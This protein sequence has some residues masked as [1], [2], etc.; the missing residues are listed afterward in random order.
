MSHGFGLVSCGT[1]VPFGTMRHQAKPHR[2]IP[3]L[4]R[5]VMLD[6]SKPGELSAHEWLLRVT[7]GLSPLFRALAVRRKGRSLHVAVES[8][9]G[10]CFVLS[11]SLV[12][13]SLKWRFYMSQ[14]DA[15]QAVLTG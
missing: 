12:T 13:K 6:L 3:D 8:V 1:V 4:S 15:R 9:Q 7:T 10:S 5:A 14:A 11:L 2:R